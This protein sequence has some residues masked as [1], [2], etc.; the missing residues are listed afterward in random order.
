K[1]AQQNRIQ[2]DDDGDADPSRD[3]GAR[4]AGEVVHYGLAT[5]QDQQRN[6]R[7][8]QREAEDH[9]REDQD[10]QRVQPGGDDEDRRDDGD[11]AAQEDGEL[12]VE[13]AL[14]DHLPGHAADRRGRSP[15][16]Q[17]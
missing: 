2:R 12:D 6:Q 16:T 8:G 13:E 14:D 4:G 17:N 15:R 5:G 11:Q 7:E 3:A 10:A 9:L 1:L